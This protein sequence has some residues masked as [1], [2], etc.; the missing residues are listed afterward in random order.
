LSGPIRGTLVLS[1]GATQNE[2]QINGTIH[3]VS[4]N[5]RP[6]N[7]PLTFE[8][9]NGAVQVTGTRIESKQIKGLV[10][11][12][13]DAPVKA[14]INLSGLENLGTLR[15]GVSVSAGPGKLSAGRL[16]S[17]LAGAQTFIEPLLNQDKKNMSFNPFELESLT[18]DLQIDDGVVKTEN[19]K[20]K[21]SELT[22]GA[23]A[24]AN[25]KSQQFE[26]LSYIKASTAPLSAIGSLPMVKDIIK[27]NEGFLKAT[28][29]DKELRKLGIDAS[30]DP[31][32]DAP[33]QPKKENTLNLIIKI[34]GLWAEPTISP[35]MENALQRSQLNQ[36]KS[37]V[38]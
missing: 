32:N 6:L 5:Y 25:L 19:L 18:A 22:M 26:A 8:K 29:L 3:L 23:I 21:T 12:T 31:A 9:I 24:K 20:L 7:S 4:L 38:N 35:L 27:K 30:K 13:V 34:A 11:G 37:L 14:S 15:G 33:E 28:G 10:K 36:L 2:P 1:G 17:I 16:R